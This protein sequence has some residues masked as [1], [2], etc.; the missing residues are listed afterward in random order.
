MHNA[1]FDPSQ[2]IFRDGVESDIP[3]CLALDSDFE[4]EHV[5]QMTVQE[6]GDEIQVNCRKQRLPR[7]LQ[8]RHVTDPHHLES[9]LR[10]GYC[11]VVVQDKSSNHILGYVSMR[12]DEG[13]RVA[14][15]QDIVIDRPFRRRSLGSRLV[16]VARVWAGEYNLRQILFEIPTTNFPCILFAK[17]MGFSFCGFNDHHFA[18]R[19]IAIFFS[20]SI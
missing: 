19:E 7:Q 18:N 9:A 1:G 5:W 17:A 8:S 3:Y 16:H 12:V 14:Y 11:F 10:R 20:L 6:V 2:L 15:L 4:S 13:S